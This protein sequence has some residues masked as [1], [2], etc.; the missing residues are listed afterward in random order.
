MLEVN[1]MMFHIV[2]MNTRYKGY[3][4]RGYMFVQGSSA[5]YFARNVEHDIRSN[6]KLYLLRGVVYLYGTFASYSRLVHRN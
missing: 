6:S 3:T 1:K 4:V 2:D 5:M